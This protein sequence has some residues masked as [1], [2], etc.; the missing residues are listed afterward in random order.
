MSVVR[1][2]RALRHLTTFVTT[3]CVALHTAALRVPS[4]SSL[5][6]PVHRLV[7]DRPAAQVAAYTAVVP[8][9]PSTNVCAMVG[10]MDV[11]RL[12]EGV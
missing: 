9:W 8:P 1:P 3:G 10:M 4:G 6:L 11:S 5:V 12:D 7:G 2:S